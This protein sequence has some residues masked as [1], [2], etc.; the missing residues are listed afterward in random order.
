[1]GQRWIVVFVACIA[2]CGSETH[3]ASEPQT[4][5]DGG[6]VLAVGA[7]YYDGCNWCTCTLFEGRAG[8]ECT[9]IACLD[10]ALDTRT[11]TATDT[12]D[13]TGDS[14]VDATLD[15]LDAASEAALCDDKT[16]GGGQVCVVPCCAPPCK[17]ARPFCADVPST[18]GG[19][20]GCGCMAS[21]CT[22]GASCGGMIDGRLQCACF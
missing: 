10:S 21:A 1:M 19:T 15:T 13:A 11:D 4:C 17:P 18:C 6:V 14:A 5:V 16:C 22:G 12:G 8:L 20:P 2:G 9:G 7:R 3:G